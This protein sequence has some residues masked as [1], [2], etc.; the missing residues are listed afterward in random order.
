[1]DRHILHATYWPPAV[2]CL[3]LHLQALE[4]VHVCNHILDNIH[5]CTGLRSAAVQRQCC[6]CNVVTSTG[7]IL[8]QFIYLEAR[9]A[10]YFL[11]YKGFFRPR[12][13]CKSINSVMQR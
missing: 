1:M 2:I 9:L 7:D 12:E 3:I 6:L 8:G 10:S 13:I 5:V 4:L 11:G